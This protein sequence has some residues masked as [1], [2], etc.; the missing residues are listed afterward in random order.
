MGARNPRPQNF[1]RLLF[2]RGLFTVS[3]DD[4]SETGTTRSLG[5]LFLRSLVWFLLYSC[6][7]DRQC[8]YFGDYSY[9]T[10]YS[11]AVLTPTLIFTGGSTLLPGLGERLHKEIATLVNPRDP[12]R[13]RVISPDDRKH[14]VWSGS[15]VL[16]GLS[17]FPQ[18]CISMQEYD[19]MGPEIVHRKCF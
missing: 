5:A 4:L 14:A 19:E 13:V 16:A 6:N 3:L 7:G 2:P 1:A 18:M 11:C 12:G 9:D 15:A 8:D 10:Q 17:T